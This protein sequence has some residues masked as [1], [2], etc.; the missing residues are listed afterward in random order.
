[1]ADL[2]TRSV[3]ILLEIQVAATTRT[4]R[5]IKEVC[6]RNRSDISLQNET[7]LLARSSHEKL[8][9]PEQKIRVYNNKVFGDD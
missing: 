3:A 1:M 5:E 8:N 6:Y 4:S 2:W 7:I 9:F